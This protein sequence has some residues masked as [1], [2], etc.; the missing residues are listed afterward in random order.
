MAQARG[1][2]PRPT[3]ATQGPGT[4]S[5]VEMKLE[6]Y[7][8]RAAKPRKNHTTWWTWKIVEMFLVKK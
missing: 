4:D 3:Y 1:K 6:V 5:R 7:R 2:R 8:A